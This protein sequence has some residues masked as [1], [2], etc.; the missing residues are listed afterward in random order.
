[1]GF[2]EVFKDEN[3]WNEKAIAGFISLAFALIYVT[4]ALFKGEVN[5]D[6]FYGLL[7]YSGAA[8]GVAALQN[9]GKK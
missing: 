2:K 8:L 3:S 1:M 9:I 5:I 7:T 6:V 4:I